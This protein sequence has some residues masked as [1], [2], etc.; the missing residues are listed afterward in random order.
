MELDT[1]GQEAAL[2]APTPIREDRTPQKRCCCSSSDTRS[3]GYELGR[4]PR[5]E[6]S[7][8][9]GL[10]IAYFLNLRMGNT[11]IDCKLLK[12]GIP[13]RLEESMFNQNLRCAYCGEPLAFTKYGIEAWRVRNEYVCNEFCADGISSTSSDTVMA[14]LRSNEL[15]SSSP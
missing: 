5:K 9:G 14:T 10:W 1:R 15:S 8:H 6:H 2:L 7:A 13:L 4:L 3:P 11:S 12:A